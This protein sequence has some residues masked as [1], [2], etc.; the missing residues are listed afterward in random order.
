MRF[1][2]LETET[3]LIFLNAL[4]NLIVECDQQVKP[5]LSKWSDMFEHQLETNQKRSLPTQ[6]V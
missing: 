5:P 6:F 2:V 4:T 1:L 3:D